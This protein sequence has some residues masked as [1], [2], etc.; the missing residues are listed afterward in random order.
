MNSYS[1][2]HVAG[3][4]LLRD[5]A[6]IVAQER[7]TTATM[8]AHIAEVDERELYL[9]TAFPSM[10]LYCVHE[11]HMS[12][13]TAFRRIR[14]ARTARRLPAIFHA[15]ADGRLNLTS[16]LLL[17]PHLTA[18]T[19]D[20]LIEA[21]TYRTKAQMELLLAGRFPKPD[22]PTLVRAIAA[23]AASEALA[24]QPVVP[25]IG[26]NVPTRME[27]LALEPVVPSVEPNTV[28]RVEPLAT[29]PATPA[30]IH[31][32]LTASSPGRFALQ[33][34]MGQVTHD[35]LR[36]AQALL[37]HAV[38]SGDVEAVL[39]RA[40][41]ELVERLRKQKFADC[42]H[43][44]PMRVSKN[45]RCIPREIKPAVWKRDDGQ[46]TFVS[47]SGRRCE[48]RANLEFDHVETV[49]RGGDS[50]SRNIRLL[51]RAHNNYEAERAYGREFMCGKRTQAQ[52]RA[53]QVNV[54][55]VKATQVRATRVNA[56]DA[57]SSPA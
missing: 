40:L 15:I 54:A 37:G 31:P 1:L 41:R 17:T 7:S 22:L 49:A 52:E 30:A 5:L 10:Y 55:Q 27:P 18:G 36:E 43:V 56:A 12:E 9:P 4:V 47:A 11:L 25:S 13:E 29:P 53:T 48:E 34:T 44:R 19:V 3:P 16:V 24:V 38:P 50:T 42:V 28:P 8:L 57:A 32:R 26:P 39:Q 23:P 45:A 6:V 33:L 20:E 35:L 14:V 46:C 51:C 2:K 21:A